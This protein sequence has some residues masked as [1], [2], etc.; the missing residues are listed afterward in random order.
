MPVRSTHLLIERFPSH[1]GQIIELA[2]KSE[3][4][5][6]LCADYESA[7]GAARWWRKTDRRDASRRVKEYLD[8]VRNLETEIAEMLAANS[9]SRI[10]KS[11]EQDL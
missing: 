7:V 6:S 4:F 1:W 2:D 9:T 8:M 10:A 3:R 11:W 5:R